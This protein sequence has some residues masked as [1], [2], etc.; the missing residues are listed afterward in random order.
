[1][2]E[3]F[4]ADAIPDVVIGVFPF[5]I[6]LFGDGQDDIPAVDVEHGSVKGGL[7]VNR[8]AAPSSASLALEGGRPSVNL[9]QTE[10]RHQQ[11]ECACRAELEKISAS[12]CGW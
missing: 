8:Q 1:M 2:G 7:V 9:I 12:K 6:Q 5:D 10:F 11:A 4:V 3:T